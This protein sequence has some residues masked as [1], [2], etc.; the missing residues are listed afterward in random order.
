MNGDISKS[1][2]R[3]QVDDS[4][5]GRLSITFH[6]FRLLC[7]RSR[8]LR[9]VISTKMGNEAVDVKCQRQRYVNAMSMLNVDVKCQRHVNVKCQR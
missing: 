9:L 1:K 8:R 7:R 2:K 3:L 6:R 5:K 4:E